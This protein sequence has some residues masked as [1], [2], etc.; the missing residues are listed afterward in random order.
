MDGPQ[1]IAGGHNF[2]LPQIIVQIND[3]D[4]V[5]R[6]LL[7]AQAAG[8]SDLA[9]Y[10]NDIEAHVNILRV[11]LVARPA[12]HSISMVLPNI[13]EEDNI[14][15]VPQFIEQE[16]NNIPHL[17]QIIEEEE[18]ENLEQGRR[19]PA[20]SVSPDVHQWSPMVSP[21]Y[22]EDSMSSVWSLSS[23]C[24]SSEDDDSVDS[25]SFTSGLRSPAKRDREESCE[26]RPVKRRRLSS[27]EHSEDSTPSSRPSSPRTSNEVDNSHDSTPSTSGCS[28]PNKRKCE[29]SCEPELR[30]RRRSEV[31]GS[32]TP[33]PS[34][35]TVD[36]VEDE[37]FVNPS[38]S[39]SSCSSPTKRKSE[40]SCESQQRKRRRLEDAAQ[41][42]HPVCECTVC[43]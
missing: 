21:E 35:A 22:S 34:A 4:D 26:S 7:E 30:K 5:Q 27:Q 10:V 28:S 12:G 31:S 16:E 3:E 40:E 42:A 2:L 43:I 39:T 11:L 38:P 9:A 6:L 33:S 41:Y 25:T 32:P 29:E 23:Y 18:L 17:P 15:F 36:W 1:N 20:H 24:S 8:D 14:R 13:G 19:S 37:D